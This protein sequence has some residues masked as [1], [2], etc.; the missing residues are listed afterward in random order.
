MRKLG[1]LDSLL[2]FFRLSSMTFSSMIELANSDIL[3]DG[4]KTMVPEISER[5]SCPLISEKSPEVRK[6][7]IKQ[8]AKYSIYKI[9]QL[10]E[11]S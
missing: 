9:R 10:V 5:A 11:Q 4:K 1:I 8:K 6:K 2:T 7:V 3:N